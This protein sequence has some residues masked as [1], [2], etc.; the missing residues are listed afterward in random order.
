[1]SEVTIMTGLVMGV[2]WLVY[3]PDAEYGGRSARR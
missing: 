3:F 1:M 2:I